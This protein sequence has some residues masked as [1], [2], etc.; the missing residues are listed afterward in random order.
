MT[1][2]NTC[3]EM[4]AKKLP[5]DLHRWGCSIRDVCGFDSCC[6]FNAR[7]NRIDRRNRGAMGK[8]LWAR[9]VGEST[10]FLK[11]RSYFNL[12]PREN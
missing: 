11:N 9:G 8:A 10:I 12:W 2:I 7:R 6:R 1:A 4:K 3:A 5:R